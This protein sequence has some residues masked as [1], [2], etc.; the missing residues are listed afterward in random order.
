MSFANTT[1]PTFTQSKKIQYLSLTGPVHTLRILDTEAHMSYSHYI[2]GVL[3]NCLGSDCPVCAENQKI[4]TE[5]PDNYK[6]IRGYYPRTRRFSVNV[7]DKTPVKICPK[8]GTDNGDVSKCGACSELLTGV[9][10]TPS[11]KVKILSRGVTLFEQ[12]NVLD[13]AIMDE[14]GN[15][16]H[17]TDFDIRLIVSGSGLQKTVTP[18]PLSNDRAPVPDTLEKYDTKTLGITL[19][20]D[21]ITDLIRGI[22]L[23][24][25]FAARKAG[26][27][28][29][30]SAISAS[31]EARR[32]VEEL[33][34]N[35]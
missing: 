11:N 33:F 4:Y 8:C 13:N 3:I 30:V 7:L 31:D 32:R 20:P 35:H 28:T 27:Q 24:D 5:Y 22:S 17:L 15:Q 23:R 25:I 10:L 26:V 19:S 18:L 1:L 2:N 16:L 29:D 9:E 34:S 21:E 14:S 12:L 6:D